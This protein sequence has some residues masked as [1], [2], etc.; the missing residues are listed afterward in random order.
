MTNF[1]NGSLPLNILENVKP[2]DVIL[3]IPIEKANELEKILK[4]K[5]IYFEY[6]GVK[7]GRVNI[8]VN[9]ESS[10]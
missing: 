2:L 1:Y 8:E 3:S 10:F 4:I 5:G 7:N 6:S 9:S